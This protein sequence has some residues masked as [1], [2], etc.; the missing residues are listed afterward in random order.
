MREIA[1]IHTICLL[2]IRAVGQIQKEFF[3]SFEEKT[4]IT[5]EEKQKA[6]WRKLLLRLEDERAQQS[7]KGDGCDGGRKLLAE[8][9]ERLEW[10]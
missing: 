5:H 7:T 4:I 9:E 10:L 8:G 3:G 6:S 1:D 2:S